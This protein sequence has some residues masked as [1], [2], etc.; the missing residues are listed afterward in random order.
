MLLNPEAGAHPVTD[1]PVEL[2]AATRAADRSFERFPYYRW[3]YGERGRRFGGSDGA[4]L[5]WLCG[6]SPEFARDQVR[7]LGAVLSSRG[8]PTLLL[9]DHLRILHEELQRRATYRLLKTSA[10]ELQARRRHA[11]S[12]RALDRLAGRFLDA[13]PE[14]WRSRIPEMGRLLVAA[15]GDERNGVEKAVTSI[16]EWACD[17]DRFPARWITAVK[18]TLSDARR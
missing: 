1:D 17:A 15:V 4:W 11:V 18:K 14:P 10:D 13:A 16:E 7:W 2:A 6:Q 5:V 12:D 9:E 8:M 3:R